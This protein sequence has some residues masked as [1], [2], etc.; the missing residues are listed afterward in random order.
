VLTP[1]LRHAQNPFTEFAREFQRNHS[2]FGN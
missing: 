2:Q 1:A